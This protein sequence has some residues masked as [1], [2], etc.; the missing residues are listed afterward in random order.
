MNQELINSTKKVLRIVNTL[1]NQILDDTFPTDVDIATYLMK[2]YRLTLFE[3][4]WVA[5]LLDTLMKA[6]LAYL[7]KNKVDTK[8]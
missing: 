8:L 1:A 4:H 2:K 6:N 5:L 3:V 7:T